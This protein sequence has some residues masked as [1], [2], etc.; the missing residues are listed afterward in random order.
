MIRPGSGDLPV[1]QFDAQK[2]LPPGRGTPS[3]ASSGIF[4]RESFHRNERR[5]LTLIHASRSK[6]LYE[7]LDALTIRDYR[8]TTVT[9]F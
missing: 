8:I 1:G 3:F 9:T 5:A 7:L 6:R 4:L 2:R